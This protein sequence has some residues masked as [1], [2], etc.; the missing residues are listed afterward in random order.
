MGSSTETETLGVV[1]P[2]E[3]ADRLLTWSKHEPEEPLLP[4]HVFLFALSICSGFVCLF[5]VFFSFLGGWGGH[6]FHSCTVKLPCFLDITFHYE[7]RGITAW[8][9]VRMLADLEH[10]FCKSLTCC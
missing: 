7:Q 5:C 10:D 6:P 3:K 8:R 2:G 1:V 9:N 4:E